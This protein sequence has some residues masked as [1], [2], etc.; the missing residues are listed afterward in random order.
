MNKSRGTLRYSERLRFYVETESG[1]R[2]KCDRYEQTICTR[3]ELLRV[4]KF[5]LNESGEATRLDAETEGVR[6]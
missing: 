2:I 1:E 6:S 5:E 4:F 3:N